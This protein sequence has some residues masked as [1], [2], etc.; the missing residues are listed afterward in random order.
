MSHKQDI[1]TRRIRV[2][3][4]KC[5]EAGGLMQV[6]WRRRVTRIEENSS[7]FNLGLILVQFQAGYLGS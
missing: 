2:K 3:G 7:V 5:G 6:C 4:E 1:E